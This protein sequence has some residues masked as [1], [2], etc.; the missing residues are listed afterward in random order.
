MATQLHPTRPSLGISCH[1]RSCST[2][3]K[4]QGHF[5]RRIAAAAALASVFLAKEGFSNTK[6][7]FSFNFSLTVP[8]QT[9]EEAEAGIHYHAQELLNIKSLIDLQTWKEVQ[10][11]LRVSASHLKQDL[12]TIIQAKPGSQRLQL[13]KL[14][15]ILFN[16]VT[17]LDYAARSKDAV[18]VKECYNNIVSTINEVFTKIQ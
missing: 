17:D 13:R 8:D 1:L 10:I 4:L 11:A 6:T 12:Y 9:I 3:H 7:A 16:S 2:S 5:T 14:Y 18:L 15:S